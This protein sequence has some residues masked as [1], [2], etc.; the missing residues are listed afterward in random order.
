M[1]LFDMWNKTI[2]SEFLFSMTKLILNMDSHLLDCRKL[3]S[4]GN[5]AAICSQ[6]CRKVIIVL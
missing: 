2:I 1:A 5:R 3:R 4:D 6:V